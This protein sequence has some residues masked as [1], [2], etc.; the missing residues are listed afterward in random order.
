M[1][2]PYQKQKTLKH[3]RMTLQLKLVSL[4]RRVFLQHPNLRVTSEEKVLD[5]VFSWAAKKDGTESWKD[6]SIYHD[7]KMDDSLFSDRLGDLEILLP[8][9][10]FPLISLAVLREVSEATSGQDSSSY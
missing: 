5:A 6:A 3:L 4:N 7:C 1:S 2:A 10:R 9:V 8:N